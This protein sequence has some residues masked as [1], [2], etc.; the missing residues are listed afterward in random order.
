MFS[1]DF[2]KCLHQI[3]LFLCQLLKVDTKLYHLD[4]N[5]NRIFH[6]LDFESLYENIAKLAIVQAI[7]KQSHDSVALYRLQYDRQL[8][9]K[10][11]RKSYS[12]S[13]LILVSLN[14]KRCP[15]NYSSVF[16]TLQAQ[17]VAS[18]NNFSPQK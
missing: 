18:V 7:I 8:P 2:F 16:Q 3:P 11:W 13:I 17:S 15:S 12:T 6:A 5:I 10:R 14:R 9:G 1:S 4:F